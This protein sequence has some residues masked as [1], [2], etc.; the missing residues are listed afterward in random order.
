MFL[1]RLYTQT[2]IASHEH[3]EHDKLMASVQA[4]IDALLGGE[5]TTKGDAARGALLD[6]LRADLAKFGNELLE[7][8]DH[9]EHSFATPVARKVC[10][11]RVGTCSMPPLR[12][13]RRWV[14]VDPQGTTLGSSCW[15]RREQGRE[16]RIQ[17]YTVLHV[18]EVKA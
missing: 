17:L 15:L 12:G 8:L 9:E 16:G 3:E 5:D 10:R 18:V 2:Q 13:G 6:G 7:H 4:A 1:G 14:C 11:R